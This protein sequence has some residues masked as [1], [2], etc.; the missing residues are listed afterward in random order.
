MRTRLLRLQVVLLLIIFV[1][2]STAAQEKQVI[3]VPQDFSTIQAAIDAATPG[4]RI[5][6]APGTYEGDHP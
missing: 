2:L 5:E 4:D 1:G 3:T 6:A